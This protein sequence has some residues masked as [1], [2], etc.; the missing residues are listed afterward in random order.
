MSKLRD[1][2]HP[3]YCESDSA[4]VDYREEFDDWASFLSSEEDED[5][6]LNLVFRFD[7]LKAGEDTGLKCDTLHIFYVGQRKALIGVCCILVTESDEPSVREW[8]QQRYNHL[9]KL[10]TPFSL[11]AK[12]GEKGEASSN[13]GE[14]D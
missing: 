7:W 14:G 8:L 9:L 12:E 10:W 3:Y 13:V 11:E 1:I 2:E 4:Y 6:D 5:F